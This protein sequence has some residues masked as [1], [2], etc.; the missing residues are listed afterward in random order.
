MPRAAPAAISSGGTAGAGG[1]GSSSL[2][3]DD[4]VNAT[5]AALVN[6]YARGQ[7]GTGGGSAGTST[8]GGAGGSGTVAITMTGAQYVYGIGRG[9]GG[10][11]GEGVT[12]GGQGGSATG[13][14]AS[15]GTTTGA[16][17]TRAFLTL[18]GGKSGTSGA[19]NGLA[20]GAVTSGTATATEAHASGGT[21]YARLDATGGGGGGATGAGMTGGTGGALSNL[22][23]S[24]Y[25]FSAEAILNETG[26][27]GGSGAAGATGRAGGSITL[28]NLVSGT[29]RG[30]TITLGQ[31]ATGG[32]GGSASGGGATGVGGNASSSLNF[33]DAGATKSSLLGVTASATGGAGGRGYAVTGGVGGTGTATSAATGVNAVSS[34]ANAS[35]GYGGRG[36]S[37]GNGGAGGAALVTS[38]T[39]SSTG[40]GAATAHGYARGGYGGRSYSSGGGASGAGGAATVTSV[41]ATTSGTAT[42]T[43]NVTGGSGGTEFSGTGISGGA[44][45][46]AT[47]GGVTASS[48]GA[49]S[50]ATARGYA[51]GGSGSRGTGSGQIGGAGGTASVGPVTASGYNATVLAS[52]TGGAGGGG[53]AGA[54]GR[55]GVASTLTNDVSVQTT[56]G[57]ER[58]TQ[59]AT[60]GAGGY[61]SGGGAGGAGGG[62]ISS[63][64]FNDTANA[65]AASSLNSYAG[66][67]G[68]TGGASPSGTGGAGGAATA[69]NIGT[70]LNGDYARAIARA[71]AGG[72]GATA[73]AGGNA[74][75]SSMSTAT[76]LGSNSTARSVANATGGLKG[77]SS[78]VRGTA[79]ASATA[80]TANGQE[81]LA[82]A[83]GLGGTDNVSS[84]A[85][86][87]G[88]NVLRGLTDSAQ[89]TGAGTMNTSAEALIN[90]SF[91]G[92]QSTS[93]SAYSYSDGMP[94]ST[95][96]NSLDSGASAISAALGT[97]TTAVDFADGTQGAYVES[98][99]SGTQTYISSETFTINATGLHG[100]LM[101][102]LIAPQALGSGLTSATLTVTVGGGAPQVFTESS[103]AAANTFF[104]NDALNLGGFTASSS[105]AV[106]VSLSETF[107]GSSTG[108]GI[109][110]L[111]GI[112]GPTIAAPT[113]LTV[114]VNHSA[115]VPGVSITDSAAS[116]GE[117]FTANL[118]DTS[119]ELTVSAHG[120]TV[121]G[122]GTNSLTI[123]G[124]LTDV[125]L[126]LASLTDIDATAGADP[127]TVNV[128]DSFGG[129]A[130]AKNIAV[131]VNGIPVLNV[132]T[133]ETTGVGQSDSL[134]GLSVSESGSSGPPETFTVVVS[135]TVGVLSASVSGSDTV[136]SSNGGKTLTISGSL[137]DV[138]ASLAALHDTE[139]TAGTSVDTLTVNATDSFGNSASQQIVP[140]TVNG[141]PS[142]TAPTSTSVVQ[143]TGSAISGVSL[144][145]SGST[146]SPETF[147]VTLSD[148]NGDLSVAANG[149]TVVGSGTNSLTISGSYTD[150]NL[151]LASLSDTDATAG[152]D[153]IKLN[154]SDSFGNAATQQ[155]IGVNVVGGLSIAVPG[156]QVIGVGKGASIATVSLSDTNLVASETFTV[157][158]SDTN[159]D[160][161]VAANGSTVV[162][163]GTNSVT[164]SGSYTDVNLALASLVD[165]GAT[166]GTDTIKVNATDSQSETATQQTIGVTVNGAPS[167]AVPGAQVEGVG[168]ALAIGGISVSESG[169][170]GSP[171]TFTATLSDTNGDL[172]VTAN[173]TTLA[174]NGTNSLTISG[175]YTD[176]NLALASLSDTDATAGV[177]TIK[178]NVTDSFGNAATQQT[179]AVTVDG[180]P[181]LHVPTGTQSLAIGVASAISGVSLTESGSTSSPE[182]FTV[183][184]SDTNGNLSVAANGS[185][186]VGS[187]TNSVT[188]SGSYTDVNLALASLSDTDATAGTDTIKLNASDSFGNAATQQTIGVNVVGGLSIAV[189]GA[190][191]IG[192]GKAASIAT[193]SLSDT[194]L[195]PTET[196]TVTLSD[197]NGDLTVTANGTALAGNGTNSLTISGSYTDVNLA[198]AS[199]SDTDATAG[200]DTIKVN[201]TDSQSETATQQTIGVTVDGVPVLNVPSGTQSLASGVATAISGVSLTESGSTSSPETFTVTLSDTNGELTVSANGSTLA[202]NGT[203]SLTITGTYT[204]VNAALASLSD[205][206]ATAG[207]DTIKLNATDSFGNA[208]TQQ[209]IAVTVP[210]SGVIGWKAPVNGLWI[211]ASKWNPATVPGAASQADISVAGTYTVTSAQNNNVG[212]LDISDANATLAINTAST[213]TDDDEAASLNAG[214]IRIAAGSA[215]NLDSGTF[216]DSGVITFSKSGVPSDLGISGS[217][218]L[219][220]GGE[221][222]LLLNSNIL[223]LV[224]GATLTNINDTI[225]GAG[226]VGNSQ[227]GIA[228]EGT[229]EALSGTLTVNTGSRPIANSGILASS[230]GHLVV[231][232]MVGGTGTEQLSL[233]GSME[234]DTAVSSGQTVNFADIGDT[235]KLD[236]AQSFTGKLAGLAAASSA[237]F[238]AVDLANFK[239]GDTSITGVTGTGAAGSTT[240]VTLTDSVDRLTTTLHLLNQYANQFAVTASDYSLTSDKA[241]GV[242]GTDFSVDYTLGTPNHGIGH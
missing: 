203:N 78:T 110:Y 19:G 109:E 128:S 75:A 26:G 121:V 201:A 116:G 233:G 89:V 126:A 114:G 165:T 146:S 183:T 139:P 3:F 180:V 232:S 9:Y 82:N 23:A 100:E 65:V 182:T 52:Q 206:D 208:A 16:F 225:V 202:G 207:G 187:G 211:T 213:F 62:A 168:K 228:N 218:T 58:L 99:S 198:L 92:F 190:Q 160:L 161:S 156:A 145:E 31:S 140:L 107:S 5:R 185:T 162:G 166:A 235:L 204:Q 113:T 51:T 154:A 29:S 159:G 173:G 163:S 77:G 216:T 220:G 231:V 6:G 124:S 242:P 74:Q 196:F 210:S 219:N 120:S 192:V 38:V 230:A 195:V 150:V 135:D 44:G 20:G 115:S 189:P 8:V 64:T 188:I 60:G 84:T 142:I 177:D 148:T 174:G 138:N 85:N 37:G 72:S 119:G 186:V 193:V 194:N 223:G 103:L 14:A 175:S 239:F 170:N 48:S 73:G 56:G 36:F 136:N 34:T 33:T 147:T 43:A 39:A 224:S 217:V 32:A 15:I 24:A 57:T 98:A 209:T 137:T 149:S 101:L 87:S 68:G 2:S 112:N 117:T 123:S 151:A 215:F 61:S 179:I 108:Y 12:T 125:N 129:S 83:T 152:T 122:S 70:S 141:A 167:I 133:S 80:T 79:T 81:A 118:S 199:L 200:A 191:V 184:L 97:A 13:T 17:N 66:A 45:G 164:I 222:K 240:N 54:S 49:A 221:V 132:P 171:E 227:L 91:L 94:T 10:A 155:T 127:I 205:T 69:S 178:V 25:G 95:E 96:V 18:A 27:A 130:A 197:T 229:I 102:G 241:P 105:L 86:T 157:T 1:A 106:T 67:Y 144:T 42:A 7:G 181:V 76:G 237:S 41:S 93:F 22:S 4:T 176:V 47:I 153:T 21:A 90:G 214:T 59:D 71:G 53:Y 11:G 88:T 55:A 234:F 46:A 28:S 104:T 143:G 40:G 158:L 238:D 212:S 50:T 226:T 169:S 236:A 131:T 35:G 134:T 63:L 30:G 111:I 172:S